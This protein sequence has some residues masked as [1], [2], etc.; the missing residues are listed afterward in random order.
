MLARVCKSSFSAS[1]KGGNEQGGKAAIVPGDR[2]PTG[3]VL[4]IS[5]PAIIKA[6]L[7]AAAQE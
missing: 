7:T 5:K 6:V 4:P 1:D 3:G 2:L